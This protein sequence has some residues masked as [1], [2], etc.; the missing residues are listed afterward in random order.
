MKITYRLAIDDLVHFNLYHAQQSPSVRRLNRWT[1]VIIPIVMVIV[2]RPDSMIVAVCTAAGAFGGAL[3]FH[4]LYRRWITP[5]LI[6]RVLTE[7]ATKGII[8]EHELEISS[9]GVHERTSMN[10][11]RHSWVSVD[12][13]VEDDRYIFIYLQVTMAHIIPKSSFATLDQANV[14]INEARALKAAAS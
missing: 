3:L 6:R 5:W 1:F 13:I 12:R 9:D 14:F 10:D 2:M 4:W 8:G 7:G 11:G